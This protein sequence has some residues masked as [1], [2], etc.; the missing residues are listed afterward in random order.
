MSDPVHKVNTAESFFRSVTLWMQ[1]G[2]EDKRLWTPSIVETNILPS[3]SAARYDIDL[4]NGKWTR[5]TNSI[6]QGSQTLSPRATCGP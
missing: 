6:Q 3:L 4:N 2:L 5:R 1:R